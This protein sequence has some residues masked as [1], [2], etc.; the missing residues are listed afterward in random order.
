MKDRP[1]IVRQSSVQSTSID[2]AGRGRVLIAEENPVNQRVALGM[3]KRLGYEASVVANGLLALEAVCSSRFDAVLMDSQMPVMDGASATRRIRTSPGGAT[4]PIIALTAS[5]L[6]ADREFL[7]A[8]G[9]DDY[10]TKPVRLDELER[11]LS[12][13]IPA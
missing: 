5:A 12:R 8:A 6:I 9:M 2:G 13:W 10:L 7:L 3:L 11:T 1:A 4:L